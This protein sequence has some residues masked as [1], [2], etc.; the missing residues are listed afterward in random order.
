MVMW[1]ENVLMSL[2]YNLKYIEESNVL[3]CWIIPVQFWIKI[4]YLLVGFKKKLD[5]WYFQFLNLPGFWKKSNLSVMLRDVALIRDRLV[6]SSY[7]HLEIAVCLGV[8]FS[9]IY[10]FGIEKTP[11]DIYVECITSVGRGSV[12]GSISLLGR[13]DYGTTCQKRYLRQV[14]LKGKW[15]EN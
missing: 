3:S 1:L 14:H 9:T 6:V 8:H 2:Q 12:R 13:W 15:L 5:F 11:W 4:E 7:F 10:E